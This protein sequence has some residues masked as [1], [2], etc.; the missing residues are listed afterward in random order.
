MFYLFQ[1]ILETLNNSKGKKGNVR[2]MSCSLETGIDSKPIS[3]TPN[4]VV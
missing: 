3:V 1:S 2:I 4:V